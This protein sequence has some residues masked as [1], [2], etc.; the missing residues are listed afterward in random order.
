MRCIVD[1]IQK[2]VEELQRRHA[3]VMQRK[4]S[5]SGQLQARKE[6]LAAIVKEIRDAGYDPKQIA[7]IRDEA[8]ADLLTEIARYEAELSEVEAALEGFPTTK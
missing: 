7:Q 4:A 8:K 6:E 3:E 5:A 1:D 2:R